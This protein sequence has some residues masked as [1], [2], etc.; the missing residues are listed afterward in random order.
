MVAL[1]RPGPME[2][3]PSYIRRMHGEETIAYRHPMLESILKETYGITVYQEQ[4]MFTA[5]KLAGYTA[6]EADNLRKGVAK[7]KADVLLKHRQTFVNGA[8]QNGVPEDIANQIFDDWEAFARYGFPKGHAADYGVIAVQTAYLKLHYPV[9]YM[10]ALLSVSKNDT[11]KVALYAADCRR[12][13][14]SVEPP[15]I[16]ASG[17]DFTIED[18][19]DGSASIRFGMGAVK[20]VGAGPV[21]AIM[22]A[23]SD[24]RFADLNDFARRVDLRQ[25]GK[26][27]LESLI[28]VG[29]LDS[30]GS[31]P[32]LLAAMD[33]ILSVSTTNFRAQDAGQMSLFGLSS[34]ITEELVLPKV[35][36]EI[37]RREI[38]NW[39]KE[40]IGLYVSDHPLSPVMEA[41]TQAVTHFS[42]QLSE[43]AQNER[44][45]VAG[46]I[47]RF[48]SYQTKTGKQMGFVT[49]EDL[50]GT[51]ELVIFPKTWDQV[52]P[53]IEADK[54]IAAEGRVDNEGSE[55]KVLVDRLTTELN[56]ITSAD[57]AHAEAQLVPAPGRSRLAA[58][59]RVPAREIGEPIAYTPVTP[60]SHKVK[61]EA[62][63]EPAQSEDW[64]EDGPPPPETFP[65]DWDFEG[66][67]TSTGTS[68]SAVIEEIAVLAAE[69]GQQERVETAAETRASSEAHDET[70]GRTGF[71]PG[72]EEMLSPGET[73]E[74]VE[75][76]VNITSP[77][78][79]SG[80]IPPGLPY[81]LAPV[82]PSD[83]E[84]VH[85]VTVILRTTGDK[86]RD[87]LRLRRIHGIASTYPG[88]DRL[89]FQVFERSRG[90][91]IEFPNFTT[92][93]C[94]ELI[95]RL[96]FLVGQEN[97]RVE[98]ITF[99]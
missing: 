20:N 75:T 16:N 22:K 1:F 55:L 74:P 95:S 79:K 81:I 44:V 21:G 29:A 62:E 41:L 67:V 24:G 17:W 57:T 96:S 27:A 78:E 32:A 90:Y 3:I 25:V 53:L 43:A 65:Q 5:M 68:L 19:D 37:N 84:T 77:V 83:S 36:T 35:T 28:K 51:V 80:I 26:R 9:E 18:C 87:V 45:R 99:Q 66:L 52:Q 49:I 8:K 31:R 61:E 71:E 34:G 56:V 92:H 97:V 76:P 13:G 58:P 60:L 40:L 88:N 10:T 72:K 39:E 6:S 82:G 73:V 50:Q 54:I 38:L 46:L 7:K 86:T 47:T 42:G 30:F 59:G 85:M 12:M 15:D 64:E 89:A 11:A 2:F 93:F 98:P 94:P 4:I 69:Q 63:E 14:I 48:R 70:E 23:R 33:R 91:L